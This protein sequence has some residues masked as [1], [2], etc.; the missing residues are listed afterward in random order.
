MEKCWL[1]KIYM[2]IDRGEL[3]KKIILMLL[4]LMPVQ[5]NAK[6]LIN[7]GEFK[8]T[9][10]CSC[11]ECSGGWGTQTATGARCQEGRT[12]AVD[13][14]VIAYGTKLLINGHVY[15]A[16][17][18]GGGVTGDHVDIYI[19]DHERVDAFGVKYA[20]IWIVKGGEWDE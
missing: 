6:T 5:A 11:S 10:Y 15:T 1:W 9:A 7:M 12:V 14:D 3:M 2:G 13:P 8:L 16:E 17:D 20:N 18:C 19:D 4:L